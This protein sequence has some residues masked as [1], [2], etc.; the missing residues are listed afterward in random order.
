MCEYVIAIKHPSQ[1][2]SFYRQG[3]GICEKDQSK[4]TTFKGYLKALQHITK[5]LVDIVLSE[6]AEI[7]I[8]PVPN[9]SP[10]TTEEILAREG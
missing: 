3:H 4:A 10:W 6:P 1:G 5:V 2:T 9:E 7:R 8:V